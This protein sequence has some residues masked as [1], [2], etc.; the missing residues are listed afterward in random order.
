MAPYRDVAFG[1]YAAD[2]ETRADGCVLLRACE[3]ATRLRE[4][5]E[6][7]AANAAPPQDAPTQVN[8]PPGRSD[9]RDNFVGRMR[10]AIDWFRNL[11]TRA[12]RPIVIKAA[13]AAAVAFVICMVAIWGVEK[14]IGNTLSCGFWG[15]CSVGATPGIDPLGLNGT[16]AGSNVSPPHSNS[17]PADGL[18]RHEI[19]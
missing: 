6:T 8:N 15:T 1:P 4:R 10:A 13:L 5:Q 3:S 18:T 17:R 9:L 2:I 14:V 16:G 19:Q 7:R 12:R 11:P